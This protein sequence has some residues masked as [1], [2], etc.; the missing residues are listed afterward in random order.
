VILIRK[1]LK[2]I[3]TGLL[4]L[5]VAGVFV[6]LGIWQLHRAA[7]TAA[8]GRYVPP[9]TPVALTTVDQAGRNLSNEALNRI[10]TFSGHYVKYYDAP[11]QQVSGDGYVD[12]IVGLFVISDNRA[13]LVVRGLNDG[14]IKPTSALLNVQGRMYPRQQDDHG[15]NSDTSLG[16]LDPSLVAGVG[17]YNLFDGYVVATQERAATGELVAGDRIPAPVVINSVSGFYWQHISYVV[18]WWFMAILTFCAP[19]ISRRSNRSSEAKAA[20]AGQY[21]LADEKNQ[22]KRRNQG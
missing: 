21:A 22:V 18:I 8:Q 14:S 17:G 7:A 9:S 15:L 12:L 4:L 1:F 5:L 13:L 19:V 20:L 11:A 10:V 2:L 3:A 16:R 6:E